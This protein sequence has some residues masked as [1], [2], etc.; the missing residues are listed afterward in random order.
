MQWRFCSSAGHEQMEVH[1]AIL[2]AILG[3]PYHTVCSVG[4][5]PISVARREG[6]RGSALGSHFR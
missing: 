3:P 2:D 5:L 6:S 1:V 4:E